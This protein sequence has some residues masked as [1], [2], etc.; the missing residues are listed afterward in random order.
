[1]NNEANSGE[2]GER[3]AKI[4]EIKARRPDAFRIRERRTDGGCFCKKNSE[5]VALICTV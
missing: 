4:E 1:M 2:G 5:S 3:T